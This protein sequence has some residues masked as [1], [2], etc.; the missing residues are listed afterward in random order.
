MPAILATP[1]FSEFHRAFPEA[2]EAALDCPDTWPCD[3]LLVLT[4]PANPTG[5]SLPIE[6]LR[7][8]L[9]LSKAAVLVDESFIEFSGLP[10]AAALIEQHPR[11]MVL[12]S[13]TKFYALPGLRIGALIGASQRMAMWKQQREP[14]QVNVLA[15]E[16]ALAALRDLDHAKRSVVFVQRERRWLSDQIH[17]LAGAEPSATDANFIFVRLKYQAA[18]LA[19]HLLQHRILIRDCTGWAGVTGEAVRIAIREH[20]QN[21]RLIKAWKEFKSA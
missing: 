9:R 11:L 4:R 6:I 8:Y 2:R 20:H 13:L 15:E 21:A 16:A 5:W 10:S 7:D 17:S 12:R 14:W 3:G 19:E 1:V 18:C